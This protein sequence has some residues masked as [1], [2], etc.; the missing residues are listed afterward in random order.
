MAERGKPVGT[1]FAELDLDTTR[2]TRAQQ[3]LLKDATSTS[4]SIE[5][6]FRK[7][8]IK[9]AAEF[10]L[11]RAKIT[12]AYDM[13]KSSAQATA[14]DILR[15]EQAKNA[16]L[17][18]INEKQFGAHA[19]LLE[20]FKKNWIAASAA[21]VGAIAMISRAI[22]YM[23]EGAQAM[24]IESSFKIMADSVGADSERMI[25]SMKKATKETIDDSDMMQKAVKLMTL[26]YDPK[27]I[28]RFSNVVIT[29]SQIAGTTAAEAY[30]NLAD[31]IANRMPKAL[32]K[33]GAVTRE[34]MAVV[35]DAIKA[36]AS[37]MA[38]Y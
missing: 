26:G 12:N 27:Q 3:R 37:E 23:D 5:E 24:Q 19:G 36:G 25:A 7:L 2:Y 22:S 16:Q 32:V 31:A 20:T 34:Q 13:I 29:A 9:S 15:A 21:V 28:E 6:N 30:E 33:M 4:L 14:N 8:G 35:N 18:A 38:L 10:D 11:M 17:K 1:I